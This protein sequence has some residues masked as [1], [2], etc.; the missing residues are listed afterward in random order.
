M[1]GLSFFVKIE[2]MQVTE[3]PMKPRGIIRIK[4]V[5]I[6]VRHLPFLKGEATKKNRQKSLVVLGMA[7]KHV[8][9]HVKDKSMPEMRTVRHAPGEA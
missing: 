2:T 9:R 5:V 4:A 1:H 3:K 6:P 7:E 8:A